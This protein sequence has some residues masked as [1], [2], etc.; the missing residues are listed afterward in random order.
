MKTQT[1]DNLLASAMAGLL[2]AVLGLTD[3]YAELPSVRDNP[4]FQQLER[5]QAARDGLQ[6]RQNWQRYQEQR[7]DLYQQE[8]NAME[9]EQ[10]REHMRNQG[11]GRPG[12]DGAPR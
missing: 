7:Y 1:T 8:Q 6:R 9:Y 10:Q 5:E 12:L 2:L 11:W 3:S 4:A